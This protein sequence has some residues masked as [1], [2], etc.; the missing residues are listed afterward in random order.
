MATYKKYRVTAQLFWDA[1]RYTTIEV[2]AKRYENASLN[3]LNKLKKLYN[4]DMIIISK[5]EEV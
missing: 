3:A 4:T 2:K 5:V 1:S